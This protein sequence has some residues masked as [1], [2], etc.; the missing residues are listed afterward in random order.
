[1]LS[2]MPLDHAMKV[3]S[4]A[5]HAARFAS[6]SNAP[7]PSVIDRDD[8]QALQHAAAL[9]QRF[10]PEIHAKKPDVTPLQR[11]KEDVLK[12]SR[13]SVIGLKVPESQELAGIVFV[14]P[15]IFNKQQEGNAKAA[16]LFALAVDNDKFPEG[17]QKQRHGKALLDKAV[18]QA[19]QNGFESLYLRVKKD[20]TKPIAL[21]QETGFKEIAFEEVVP[22]LPEKS[23]GAEGNELKENFVWMKKNLAA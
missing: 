11:L 18:E 17:S 12:H 10:F 3:N 5:A 13:S 21:Y 16:Y 19:K 14:M 15:F 7:I 6:A 23:Q 2:A 1:M 22:F 9:W 4:Y 8:E 20:E